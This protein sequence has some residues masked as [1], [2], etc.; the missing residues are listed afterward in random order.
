MK[1]RLKVLI[2]LCACF[3]T[4]STGVDVLA[5]SDVDYV[6]IESQ[7]TEENE[8]Y[9]EV[10]SL[11]RGTYLFYGS[12]T[13]TNPGIGYVGTAAS[14]YAKTSVASVSVTAR[15]QRYDNGSWTTVSSWTV[16]ESNSTNAST[17]KV[18]S[19]SRGYYYRV[20]SYH[21]ANGESTFGATN[22]IY[23]S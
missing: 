7:L 8:S 10:Y 18:F 5:S 1:K 11:L 2:A 20:Y 15:L 22:G 23:I 21:S 12:A 16:S 3:C 13:I 9:N 19:V 6:E 17:S 14:T 4:I